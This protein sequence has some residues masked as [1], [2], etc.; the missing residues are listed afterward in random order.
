MQDFEYIDNQLR[1]RHAKIAIERLKV[2]HPG[3]DDDGLWYIKVPG[4]DVEVQIESFS[5]N[6]PFL[7]ESSSSSQRLIG[8]S[9]DEVIQLVERSLGLSAT[10][11]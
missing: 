8:H 4:N 1:A 2:K 10:S 9:P 7:I 6:C 3:A 5:G 11:A